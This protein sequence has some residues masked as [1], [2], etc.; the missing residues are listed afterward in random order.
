MNVLRPGWSGILPTLLE[1]CQDLNELFAKDDTLRKKLSL[2]QQLDQC[3]DWQ[4]TVRILESWVINDPEHLLFMPQQQFQNYL[5]IPWPDSVKARPSI[6][7]ETAKWMGEPRLFGLLYGIMYANATE[8]LILNK[9]DFPHVERAYLD[10]N[11]ILYTIASGITESIEWL[12]SEKGLKLHEFQAGIPKVI[13]LPDV[14]RSMMELVKKFIPTKKWGDLPLE[15]P[16]F[17][18]ITNLIGVG[19]KMKPW[20]FCLEDFSDDEALEIYKLG[21]F[22]KD[23]RQ[24]CLWSDEH[25]KLFHHLIQKGVYKDERFWHTVQTF[26]RSCILTLL[27]K[28]GVSRE[29]LGNIR[30]DSKDDMEWLALHGVKASVHVFSISA[31][32]DAFRV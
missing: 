8:P 22:A 20:Y 14:S 13:F 7:S 29:T 24:E 26:K 4:Q 3:S 1:D 6:F 17:H 2:L 30:C 25:P 23:M 27:E 18:V 16:C 21:G 11:I 12:I 31:L 15:N 28:E 9:S 32:V 10:I 19:M 5:A